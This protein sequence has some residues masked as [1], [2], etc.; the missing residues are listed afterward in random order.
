MWNVAR[1]WSADARSRLALGYALVVALGVLTQALWW[2]AHLGLSWLL[3]DELLV[4]VVLA[5]S[6]RGASRL[7]WGWG[8]LSVWL[9]AMFVWYESDWAALVSLPLSA[10]LLVTL[11][12]VVRAEAK[13]DTVVL[14]PK[15]AVD[16]AA[17]LPGRLSNHA[18]ATR[19][20]FGDAA[21][22]HASSL[23]RGALLGVPMSGVCALLLAADPQF[24]TALGL[25]VERLAG[26]ARFT[27]C[28]AGT[29]FIYLIAYFIMLR[30]YE[31]PA[32]DALAL[33]TPYR[34][35]GESNPGAAP[36]GPRVRPLTWGIVLAQLVTLFATFA[37]A[38]ARVMFA[39]HA[40]I[41]APGTVTYAEHLHAGFGQVSVAT[42]IA[43]LAVA[44]GHK[45]TRGEAP[46]ETRPLALA[47]VETLLLSLVAVALASCAMRLVLY[48]EVYGRT[49]Q[50]VGVAFFQ[51][52]VF[53]LIVLTA[54]RSMRPSWKG[55]R[56]AVTAFVLGLAA[57]A[58]SMNVDRYIAIA[59]ADA[60]LRG[61]PLDL[62]YLALLSNDAS[63]VLGHPAL[64]WADSNDLDRIERAWT[65]RRDDRNAEGWR[66]WRGVHIP[67]TIRR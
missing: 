11:P 64:Y 7:A 20:A 19:Q 61:R 30:R 66:A 36:R 15:A 50:R 23:W 24:A 16:A 6:R 3:V 45:L 5:F 62:S 56:A 4:F 10:I 22:N 1:Q 31:T 26:S 43:V 65:K 25:G 35:P 48:E 33:P 14:L 63:P 52:F 58:G 54:I 37:V 47:V 60:V 27:I 29:A 8:G 2:D 55:Y 46:N 21:S 49:Y 42:T 13:L 40:F 44:I 51:A 28:A 17:S 34:A 18:T 32:G 57:V 67:W 38:N 53:G 59:N 41:R 9:A 39:G 12:L